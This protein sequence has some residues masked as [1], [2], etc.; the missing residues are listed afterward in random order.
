MRSAG[1]NELSDARM[2]TDVE[3]IDGA[4]ESVLAIRGVA[5]K[6]ARDRH[7]ELNLPEGNQLGLIAQEVEPVLP[8][9]VQTDVNGVKTVEYAHV[10][11]VLIEAIKEQQRLLEQQGLILD[12]VQSELNEL[13]QIASAE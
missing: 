12:R 1:I 13:R 3:T 4:L 9:L 8:E 11:A 5:Y 10:V 7:P 2:K 6:W